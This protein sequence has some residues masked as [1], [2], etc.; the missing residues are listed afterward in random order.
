MK[1]INATKPHRKSWVSGTRPSLPVEG[2]GL[3]SLRENSVNPKIG[4]RPVGPGAKRPPSPAGLG[5]G[6]K[7]CP[8]PSGLG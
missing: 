6:S 7:G 4:S 8:S 3:K 5:G 2:A 1:F